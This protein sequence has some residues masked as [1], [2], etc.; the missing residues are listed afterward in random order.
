MEEDKGS[1]AR[2]K[3]EEQHKEGSKRASKEQNQTKVV[4][5]GQGESK[6]VIKDMELGEL[7]LDGIEKAYD[8][9]TSGYISFEQIALLKEEII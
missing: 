5:T 8:N 9:P 4:P 3:Q 6:M 1:E 2:E 7:D